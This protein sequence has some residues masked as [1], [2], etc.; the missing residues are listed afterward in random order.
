[1]IKDA[2][3][4][5]YVERVREEDLKALYPP[6]RDELVKKTKNDSLKLQRHSVWR[7]LEYALRDALGIDIN[8]LNFKNERGR[9]TAD[10]VCFSLSHADSLV[11]VAVSLGA[12]GVD[13]E[14]IKPPHSASMPNRILTDTELREYNALPEAEKDAYIIAKWSMKEALFKRSGLY[15]F[16][17]HDYP[18]PLTSENSIRINDESCAFVVSIAAIGDVSFVDLR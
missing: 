14:K 11:A 17:P 13:I 4:F 18:A 16:V 7:L 8:S 9:W 3:A 12:V 5:V 1:M 2:K 6:E 10:G 15:V